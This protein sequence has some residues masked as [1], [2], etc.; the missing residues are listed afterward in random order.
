MTDAAHP[1]CRPRTQGGFTLIEVM[2]TVAIVAI[3]GMVAM[4]SYRDYVMRGHL[5]DASNGLA[6]VR[7]DMERHFQ[8]NRTYATVGTF[9]T[10]CASTNA[11]TR[12]FNLFVVSCVGTPTG[13][14]FTLQAVGSGAASGFTFTVD[15]T[16]VRATTAAPSGWTTCATKWLLKRGASC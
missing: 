7:A 9:V 1:P 11:A 2:I 16:D 3:L 14:A 13:T 5:A 8:D 4:P 12:T 6:A 15:Q 10:P